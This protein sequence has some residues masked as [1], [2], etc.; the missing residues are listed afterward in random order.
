MVVPNSLNRCNARGAAQTIAQKRECHRRGIRY[1][2]S[3]RASARPMPCTLCL[4]AS[5]L[6]AIDLLPRLHHGFPNPHATVAHSP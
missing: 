6:K 2:T 1:R 3:A 4:Y 5:A